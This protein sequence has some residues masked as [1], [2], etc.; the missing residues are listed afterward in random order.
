MAKNTGTGSRTGTVKARSQIRNPKT[1]AFVKRDETAG[2][3]HKG[4][5]MD[6]KQGG[7]RFKGIAE[8]RAERRSTVERST[9]AASAK[10]RSARS[11]AYPAD[12]KR[13]GRAA[14]PTRQTPAR[15][16]SDAL[17]C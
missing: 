13:M 11:P 6:V 2:S 10:K 1:G 3:A 9:R 5:F 8:E 4:E 12:S 7:Q 14:V 15:K 17:C 16:Q